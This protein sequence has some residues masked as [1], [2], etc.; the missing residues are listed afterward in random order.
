MSFYTRA[1]NMHSLIDFSFSKKEKYS[2][3]ISLNAVLNYRN[4]WKVKSSLPN[5]FLRDFFIVSVNLLLDLNKLIKELMWSISNYIFSFS[6][7]SVIDNL[8]D[9]RRSL[10]FPRCLPSSVLHHLFLWCVLHNMT[11]YIKSVMPTQEEMGFVE[12]IGVF[13]T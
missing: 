4:S 7:I 11:I 5:S 9:K 1:G 12:M 10:Y 6:N 2:T 8:Y 3:W 13:L